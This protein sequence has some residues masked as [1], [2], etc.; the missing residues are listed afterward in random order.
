MVEAKKSCQKNVHVF[1]RVCLLP[2]CGKSF[3]PKRGP[4]KREHKFCSPKCR[5]EYFSLARQV[6][7]EV[8]TG[9]LRRHL[10]RE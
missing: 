3:T 6:G 1:L 2:S 10:E 7:K 5:Q 9:A 4:G 8:L